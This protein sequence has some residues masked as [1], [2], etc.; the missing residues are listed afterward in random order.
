MD[1]AKVVEEVIKHLPNKHDQKAHG[2]N[3]GKGGGGEDLDRHVLKTPQEWY[4]SMTESARPFIAEAFEKLLP[5]NADLFDRL[6][7]TRRQPRLDLPKGYIK[8]GDRYVF[9]VEGRK[10]TKG[11]Q[12]VQPGEDINRPKLFDDGQ[13]RIAKVGF[14]RTGLGKDDYETALRWYLPKTVADFS[15]IRRQRR[16]D[17]KGH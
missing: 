4:M 10:K 2:G 16:L 3:F 6:E 9:K 8:E 13:Y 1:V 17:E 12:L 5:V 15:T 11:A 7:P 14:L